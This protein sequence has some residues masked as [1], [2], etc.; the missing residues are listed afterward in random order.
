[1]NILVCI[2]EVLDPDGVITIAPS[3][4]NLLTDNNTLYRLNR[5]DEFAVEEALRI[6]D[7]DKTSISVEVVTVG[8]ARA[9]TVL[10]RALGMG[11]DLGGHIRT[12]DGV[13]LSPFI[14]ASALAS[15][16]KPK[17]FDLILTGVLAEDDLEGQVG[18][19]LAELL[20]L[21]CITSAVDLNLA[22]QRQRLEVHREIEG[23]L[24]ERLNL[25]LPGVVTIQSSRHNPR[26]PTLTHVLRAR[27][28]AL[29]T[30]PIETLET[31]EPRQR[32]F[33]IS[34]PQKSRSGQVL[35]GSP[36]EKASQLRQI[37][38]EKGLIA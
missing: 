22:P 19:L 7:G 2:K 30:I 1:M 17:T 34:Y 13:F 9:E 4:E 37:L 33:R 23:G 15:Y 18:P 29:K 31:L 8:P 32:L 25:K 26:Y 38:E 12:K 24:R 14:V 35:A 21:P 3:G 27:K 11:A 16:A 20:S 5:F 28:Q 10:R 6:K 36:R